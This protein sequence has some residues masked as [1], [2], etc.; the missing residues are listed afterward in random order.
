MDYLNTLLSSMPPGFWQNIIGYFVDFVGNYGLA[1]V[2][3]SIA[4]KIVLSPLDYNQRKITKNNTEKQAKLK[5]ELEKI[6]KKFAKNKEA[7]V[8]KY[9]NNQTMLTKE[10]AKNKEMQNQKT[11]ELYKKENYNIVGNCLG[12][13]LNFALTL[14]I[15]ISLFN[16][17][18]G[19]SEFKLTEQYTQLQSAYEIAYNENFDLTA[20]EEAAKIEGQLAAAAQYT[21]IKDSFLWVQSVWMPDTS[22]QVIPDYNRFLKLT[23]IPE[24][25][26]PTQEEYDEVM[27]I[28]RQQQQGWNG[29]YI[30][31][32]LAAI[33]TYYSQKIMQGQMKAQKEGAAANPDMP[34]MN[35]KL[36]LYLLPALMVLFTISYSAAF[37]I[38]IVINS[39]MT[40]V[41]SI[42]ANKI[43]T[44]R[45]AKK[46]ISNKP[47]YTR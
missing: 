37:A 7:L 25:S 11:M 33:I 22:A 6:N 17:M 27:T 4:L 42:I 16:A 38:Y 14:V 10:I 29:T 46:Q 40:M 12:M 2:L 44:A 45:E 34:Q 3:F 9:S 15:F 21:Q 36:F 32:F 23:N 26:R 28:A 24:E 8:K 41:I 47:D 35:T 43:I 30:L 39:A 1:I 20:D 5:P 31:I 18:R 13:F 19:I